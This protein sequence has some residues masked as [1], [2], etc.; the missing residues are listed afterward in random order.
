MHKLSVIPRGDGWVLCLDGLEL[1]HITQ[2][3]LRVISAKEGFLTIGLP[4]DLSKLAGNQ[5]A[6]TKANQVLSPEYT[7]LTVT[8]IRTGEELA[9]ITNGNTPIATVNE[10]IVVKL[11][12][13]YD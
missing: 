8:D 5:I 13:S 1:E 4:V 3:N 6:D 7:R 11:T 10:N 2:I 9:V 12:P